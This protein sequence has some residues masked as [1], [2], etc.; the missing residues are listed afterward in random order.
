MFLSVFLVSLWNRFNLFITEAESTARCWMCV[1]TWSDVAQ[2]T[3]PCKT[4]RLN[5]SIH[6]I[7]SQHVYS[8]QSTTFIPWLPSCD[9]KDCH[10]HH[11]WVYRSVHH[12]YLLIII[13][14]HH[15]QQTDWWGYPGTEPWHER[16][17]SWHWLGGWNPESR[18]NCG[19]VSVCSVGSTDVFMEGE[20]CGGQDGGCEYKNEHI[21]WKTGKFQTFLRLLCLGNKKNYIF[22]ISNKLGSSLYCCLVSFV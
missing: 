5:E 10:L 2:L 19:R 4:F 20:E 3:Q 7:S 18:L 14:H 9:L 17:M 12:L 11:G 15:L 13:I 21:T 22:I 16:H 8:C 1:E 6:W